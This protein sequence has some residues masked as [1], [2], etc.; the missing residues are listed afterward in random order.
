[1]NILKYISS[2]I[3]N[4]GLVIIIILFSALVI[5][6]DPNSKI[7]FSSLQY[8]L[9]GSIIIS[10]SFFTVDYII[11]KKK[12]K[13]FKNLISSENFHPENI[14]DTNSIENLYKQSVVSLQEKYDKL[15]NDLEASNKE[16]ADFITAWVH[17]AKLPLSALS[18]ML[19]NNTDKLPH[20]ILEDMDYQIKR[21]TNFIEKV[22]FYVKLKDFK[23][24]Y[25]TKKVNLSKIIN[26]SLKDNSYLF[27]NK[28]AHINIKDADITVLTDPKWCYFIINQIINNAGKYIKQNGILN[29]YTVSN[30]NKIKLHIFNEG[31]GIKKEDIKR[32][33][34]KGFT[35]YMGRVSYK[36]TGYGMY[37]SKKIAKN[38]NH[39]LSVN[40]TYNQFAEFTLT[41]S[42]NDYIQN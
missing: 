16:N 37:L 11:S 30:D 34:D 4:I 19:E 40:S 5:Y 8:M 1:M 7:Y 41:F 6:L 31:I 38:L 14:T 12:Y 3:K 35:G 15:L 29:I 33:F 24:D 42:K 39:K 22:L 21:I 2:N 25:I 27:I 26:N 17:D 36:S 13:E 10:F 9:I 23:N 32:V 28:N 20:D 18:M